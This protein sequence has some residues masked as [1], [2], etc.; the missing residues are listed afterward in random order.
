[1]SVTEPVPNSFAVVDASVLITGSS[2]S[3]RTTF[4]RALGVN[5]DARATLRWRVPEP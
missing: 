5:A 2:M 1:M 3:G 4:V